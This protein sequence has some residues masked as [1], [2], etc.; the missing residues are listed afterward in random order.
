MNLDDDGDGGA[1]KIA[2]NV[3]PGFCFSSSSI[4]NLQH[5]TMSLYVGIA[6]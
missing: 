3:R 1:G 4:G 2:T 6:F 5:I